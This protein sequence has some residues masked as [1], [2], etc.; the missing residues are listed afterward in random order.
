MPLF[1]M[2][3]PITCAITNDEDDS[4]EAGDGN[5]IGFKDDLLVCGDRIL[6][7]YS[8]CKCTVIMIS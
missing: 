8:V 2:H 6:T 3:A 5:T 4:D 1:S 7:A